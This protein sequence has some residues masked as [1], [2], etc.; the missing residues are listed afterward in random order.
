MLRL[1]RLRYL[2][3][4]DAREASAMQAEFGVKAMFVG[5]GTDLFPNLKRRQ[6]DP[7]ILIGLSHLKELGGVE[8]DASTGFKV[9][10]SV[11]LSQA[12][13]HTGLSNA[14]PGYSEAA[15]LVS[16]PPLRN[17]ATI[18]GNPCVDTR[19]NYYNPPSQCRRSTAFSLTNNAS[20]SLSPPA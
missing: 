14:F 15:G 19:S 20:I 18:G 1:P 9:G 6:F 13:S 7:E 16:S 10:A 12:A 2:R 8:G 11:T 17:A 5:G 3:P 4:Q